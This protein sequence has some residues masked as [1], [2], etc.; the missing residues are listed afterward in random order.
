MSMPIHQLFRTFTSF[1]QEI[2]INI[3]L[4]VMLLEL[5]IG[6]V[7]TKLFKAVHLKVENI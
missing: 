2:K 4:G 6:V 1:N 7:D 5:L 3:N